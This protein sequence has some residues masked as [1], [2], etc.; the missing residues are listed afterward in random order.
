MGSAFEGDNVTFDGD[1]LEFN[2]RGGL[3][4]PSLDGRKYVYIQ[5]NKNQSYVNGTLIT[6]LVQN[7]RWAEG[8]K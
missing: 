4:T 1:D 7:R 3:V 8:W 2:S 5:N 6:G